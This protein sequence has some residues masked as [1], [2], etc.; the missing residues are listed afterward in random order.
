[1]DKDLLLVAKDDALGREMQDLNLIAGKRATRR[2]K[3]CSQTERNG[4]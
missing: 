4:W 1:M 3:R 2:K